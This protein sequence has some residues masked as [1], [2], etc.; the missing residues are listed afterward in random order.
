VT[1]QEPERIEDWL[2]QSDPIHTWAEEGLRLFEDHLL[3]HAAFQ[4][5]YPETEE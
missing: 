3:I 5:Q 2:E 1:L 4:A